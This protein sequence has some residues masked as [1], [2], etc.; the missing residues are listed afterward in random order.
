[1]R[2]LALLFAFL[3]PPQAGGQSQTPFL[4]PD[5]WQRCV[6]PIVHID[7]FGDI[8]RDGQRLG[9][10]ARE[11]RTSCSGEV[12]WTDSSGRLRKN[13]AEI[14]SS[15]RAYE[16]AWNT[17]ALVW[18]DSG[19]RLHKDAVEL[20]AFRSYSINGYTGDVLWI[21]LSDRLHKNGEPLG[22][23]FHRESRMALFTGDA[24]WCDA[25][26]MLYKNA[27]QLGRFQDRFAIHD[28]TGAVIWRD[29]SGTLYKD[30]DPLG[31]NVSTFEV[32]RYTGDVVWKGWDGKLYK[33][34]SPIGESVASFML[35]SDGR[36][37]WRDAF[38]RDHFQ[39]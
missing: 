36:V 33:N 26:G 2:N 17:G 11:F 5:P 7:H 20:G 25:S 38:G 15:I 39:R 29:G 16:L 35:E 14:A 10:N 19:G 30:R 32:A 24:A 1:M 13:E 6:R 12:A 8:F 18:V 27:Q 4:F 37:L 22:A 3:M 31:W 23:S 34:G 28:Y 9:A 21:D